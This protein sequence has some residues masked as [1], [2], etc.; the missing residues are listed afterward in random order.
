MPTAGAVFGDGSAARTGPGLALSY[1]SA[2][3]VGAVGGSEHGGGAVFADGAV[4]GDCGERA[5]SPTDA[6]A[7]LVSWHGDD[8]SGG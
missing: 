2:R 6:L 1:G 7:F 5:Q 4:G 8:G 3:G